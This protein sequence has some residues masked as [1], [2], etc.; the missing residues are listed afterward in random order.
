MKQEKLKGSI[1]IKEMP[2]EERPREKMMKYGVFSLSNVELLSILIGSGTRNTTALSLAARII[3]LEKDGISF[4][5]HCLPQD[6]CAIKGIGMAKSCQIVAGIAL[7]KRIATQPRGKRLRIGSPDEVAALFM[8]EL[9]YLKKEFFRVLLLN[10]KNEIIGMEDASIGNLNSSIVHP[11]E[12]FCSAIKKSA[13]SMIVVHNHP[14][15]NPKP[16]QNDLNVTVRLVEAGKL[17]GISVVDHLIIG[18]GVYIS[19]KE[20]GLL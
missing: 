3:S 2:Q 17:L 13:S 9:R 6:L 10:T 14:S 5:G 12:I 8:E 1:T 15:G 19:L 16:S 18:D 20:K 7:G 11:R 4:L